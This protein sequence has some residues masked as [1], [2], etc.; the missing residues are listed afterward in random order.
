[1]FTIAG[2]DQLLNHG[3][4]RLPCAQAAEVAIQAIKLL[5]WRKLSGEGSLKHLLRPNDHAAAGLVT[6]EESLQT[7]KTADTQNIDPG[8]YTLIIQHLHLLRR[9]S[10]TA[11]NCLH[12]ETL[13]ASASI[14]TQAA[15][16]FLG[17]LGPP[18]STRFQIRARPDL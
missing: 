16:F 2:K 5:P 13:G 15:F 18:A 1:M 6:P 10:G 4:Y 8:S 12:P 7:G 3:H 11:T 17:P 14:M 9:G